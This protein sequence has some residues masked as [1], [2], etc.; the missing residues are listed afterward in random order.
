MGILEII[1][2]QE[3]PPP[4]TRINPHSVCWVLG[5]FERGRFNRQQAAQKL[6]LPAQMAVEL[7]AWLRGFPR[8]DPSA[9]PIDRSKLH[10]VLGMLEQGM[11]TVAEAKTELGM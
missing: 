8:V 9:R 6:N 2:G 4:N 11:Y 3:E 5:E 10:D 7:D 1:A